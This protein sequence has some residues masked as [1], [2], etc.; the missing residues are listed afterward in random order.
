MKN[1]ILQEELKRFPDDYDVISDFGGD[2][3][4]VVRVTDDGVENVIL[5]EEDIDG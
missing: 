3:F 2:N 5:V 1:G 4:K